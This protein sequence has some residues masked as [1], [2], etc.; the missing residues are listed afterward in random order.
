MIKVLSY[1]LQ[2]SDVKED[3]FAVAISLALGRGENVRAFAWAQEGMKRFPSSSIVFPLYLSTLRV[4][5]Q[6]DQILPTIQS[7]T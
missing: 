6:R 1:L 2:E 5:G 7:A 3:D 4:S